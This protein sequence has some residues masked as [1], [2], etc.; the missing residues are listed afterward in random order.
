MLSLEGKLS[1]IS[2]CDKKCSNVNNNDFKEEFI[3]F[4]DDKYDIKVVDKLYVFLN[5]S[6]LKNV[7]YHQHL[8]TPLTNGNPYLL[9]LTRIDNT[10]C[11][12]YIDRKLK[13]SFSFPKIHCVKYQFADELF[14]DTMLSGELVRDKNRKWFFLI[15]NLLIYK[16][17]KMNNE[18]I[19]SKFE[20]I[21]D[22]FNNSYTEDSTIEP[23]PIQIKKLFSYSQIKILINKFLPSLSYH[24]KGLVFYNLNTKYSN[25]SMLFPRNHVYHLQSNDDVED[26]IRTKKPTLWSKTINK[27]TETQFE[28]IDNGDISLQDN[29]ISSEDISLD[30]TNKSQIGENNMVF[31]VLHTDMPDVF[32]LYIYNEDKTELIKYDNALVPNMKTSKYLYKLFKNNKNAINIC[33]ECR[34]SSIFKK[35][36]PLRD[37]SLDP[38]TL[39]D[40]EK[41]S[42]N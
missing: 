16:G 34:Y 40:I 21:Y 29:H 14:A 1:D 18:N 28:D 10:N 38:Y 13:G 17:K 39:S 24:C 30:I 23:C 35:W 42:D 22:I 19:V 15:D 37:V 11:C 2:F 5:P 6:I 33:M 3:R 31:K 26:M 27:S 32:N 41:I 7:L 12:F 4:I 25:Y 9:Y 36:I 8:L 20:I